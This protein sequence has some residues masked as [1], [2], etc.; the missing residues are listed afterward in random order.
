MK[1]IKK[2]MK[3]KMSIEYGTGVRTDYEYDENRRWLNSISVGK[4]GFEK[5]EI[6]EMVDSYGYVISMPDVINSRGFKQRVSD[7]FRWYHPI[8]SNPL[9]KGLKKR[10]YNEIQMF[11]YSDYTIDDIPSYIVP[12][13]PVGTIIKKSG[14]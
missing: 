1:N 4:K 2:F 6:K 13:W 11:L 9:H 8:A 10:R 5:S 14:K 12:R 3:K 7:T